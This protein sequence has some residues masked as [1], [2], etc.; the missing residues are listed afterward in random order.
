MTSE[1]TTLPG[2]DGEAMPLDIKS[3]KTT[4]K[5]LKTL[6]TTCYGVPN[7]DT[8]GVPDIKILLNKPEGSGLYLQ[9]AE[10]RARYHRAQLSHLS[11]ELDKQTK[12]Y[13]AA[14]ECLDPDYV[15]N[16]SEAVQSQVNTIHAQ[17]K[18]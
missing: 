8:K 14:I 5:N 13:V 17:G 18:S 9:M 4:L 6:V 12:E 3:K 2:P 7:K 11:V 15:F 16:T 1:L 10:D